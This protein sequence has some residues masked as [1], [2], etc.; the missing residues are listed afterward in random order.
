[1]I[2][3]LGL[4]ENLIYKLLVKQSFSKLFLQFGT[5]FAISNNSPNL[6]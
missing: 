6:S 2:E 4:L 3:I 5:K 1:M